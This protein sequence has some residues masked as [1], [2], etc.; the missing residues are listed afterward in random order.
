[1]GQGAQ[2]ERRCATP[3]QRT[4]TIAQEGP[5][6]P[7]RDQ[8]DDGG[9]SGGSLDRPGL[10]K[11]RDATKKYDPPLNSDSKARSPN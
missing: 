10:Q 11:L 6:R 9:F 1:V 4:A 3:T 5:F 8:N 2:L 7:I